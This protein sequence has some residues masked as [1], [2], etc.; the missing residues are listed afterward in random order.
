MSELWQLTYYCFHPEFSSNGTVN[1]GAIAG[2]V[3]A[4]VMVVAI[5]AIGVL[6][7]VKYRGM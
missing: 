5:A 3:V 6:V 1:A 4:G 2:G 7:F